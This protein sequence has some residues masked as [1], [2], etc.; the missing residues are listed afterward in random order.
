MICAKRLP[1][2][3]YADKSRES[4]A[5]RRRLKCAGYSSTRSGTALTRPGILQAMIRWLQVSAIGL[6]TSAVSLALAFASGNALITWKEL[7]SPSQTAIS[8]VLAV[9]ITANL[10]AYLLAFR[11]LIRALLGSFLPRY[12]AVPAGILLLLVL[13]CVWIISTLRIY[14]ELPGRP[15][16][17]ELRVT[18]VPAQSNSSMRV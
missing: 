16:R 7:D 8:V 5:T 1:R 15:A 14:G 10:A 2:R 18:R 4:P 17:S 11:G 6:V 3:G 9:V 13:F 12:W